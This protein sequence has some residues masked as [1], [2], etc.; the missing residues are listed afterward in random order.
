[1]SNTNKKYKSTRKQ[2]CKTLKKGGTQPVVKAQS[3]I[4]NHQINK[5]DAILKKLCKY[6]VLIYNKGSVKNIFYNE[7]GLTPKQCITYKSIIKQFFPKEEPAFEKPL[8]KENEISYNL[9]TKVE[10]MITSES[11]REEMTPAVHKEIVETIPKLQ[12]IKQQLPPRSEITPKLIPKY[13]VLVKIIKIILDK[14][15]TLSKK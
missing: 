8:T 10:E 9:P 1:M 7:Y 3:Q 2:K 14:L 11:K 12:E 6:E 13:D 15:L 5:L 4:L